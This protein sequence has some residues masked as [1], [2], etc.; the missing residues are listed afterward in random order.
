M[1]S[2]SRAPRRRL[3]EPSHSKRKPTCPPGSWNSSRSSAL[4]SIQASAGSQERTVIP[5]ARQSRRP[6]QQAEAV[7]PI[8]AFNRIIKELE[9]HRSG[10]NPVT[11]GREPPGHGSTSAITCGWLG[12]SQQGD[13]PAPS[14]SPSGSPAKSGPTPATHGLVRL[15]PSPL[16]GWGGAIKATPQG[17]VPPRGLGSRS[18]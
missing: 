4:R 17:P 1:R 5:L 3:Q 9:I 2:T 16:R 10:R 7:G 18:G 6:Q 8:L 13:T 12:W 14:T 11:P 15:R